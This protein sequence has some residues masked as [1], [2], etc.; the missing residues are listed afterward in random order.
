MCPMMMEMQNLNPFSDQGPDS[1]YIFDLEKIKTNYNELKKELSSRYSECDIFYSYKTNYIPA[2]LTYLHGLGAKAEVVS[3][4]ELRLALRLGVSGKD[5]I[6]NGPVKKEEDLLLAFKVGALV[7]IDSEEE[8]TKIEELNKARNSKELR[9]GIRMMFSQ[10][11]GQKSRFGVSTEDPVYL[12][13][14]ANRVMLLSS[15]N[16]IACLHCHLPS[17]SLDSWRSRIEQ[18]REKIK[19]LSDFNIASIDFGGG[20]SGPMPDSLL[21]QLG[22][23]RQQYSDYTRILGEFASEVCG[24]YG[25]QF[26]LLIEPGTALV[27][28]VGRYYCRVNSIKKIKYGDIISTTGSVHCFGSIGSKISYPFSIVPNNTSEKRGE[29]VHNAKIVG[30]SCIERDVLAYGYEGPLS[31]GDILEFKNAGS[32][33]VVMKPQFIQLAPEI[34]MQKES[35]ELIL[36]RRKENLEDLL[37]T[38]LW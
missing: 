3:G 16:R 1:F 10:E 35:G 21:S 34:Y 25:L 33:S 9:V 32:Y 27:A 2:L 19:I 30:Y 24:E 18:M 17:R 15:E 20:M 26:R 31:V 8:L 29:R 23:K 37:S 22:G 11:E 36:A 7:N 38:Y 4:F 6:F 12:R 28:D 13:K 5:I 14:I